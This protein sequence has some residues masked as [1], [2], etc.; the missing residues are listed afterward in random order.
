[1]YELYYD[2]MR[3]KYGLLIPYGYFLKEYKFNHCLRLYLSLKKCGQAL[4]I[5]DVN[6]KC[7]LDQV[8][9]DCDLCMLLTLRN[10]T[11]LKKIMRIEINISLV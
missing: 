11:V 9:C 5:E 4:Y 7:C 1:M 10:A 6:L 8:L 2:T 3:M